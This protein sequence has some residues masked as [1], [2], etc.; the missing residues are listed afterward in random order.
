MFNHAL[1]MAAGRGSRMLPL[2]NIVPKAMAPLSNTTLI[3]SGIEKLKKKI[4]N[5]HVTVGY[6]GAMLASHV[7]EKDVASVFNTEGKGNAW[8]VYHTL[9]QHL[10]EPVLV[11]TCDNVINLNLDLLKKDYI[12]MGQPACTVIPVKPVDG[13][14]G[15][16]IFHENNIV[17]ELNRRKKSDIYCSGIQIINP[18]K[19][20]LLTK[21]VD[22]FYQLWSQLIDSRKLF[23]SKIYPDQWFT[24]DTLS[25]LEEIN[26]IVV[27]SES[28][29][30]K[31]V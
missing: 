8:W 13:L 9:I 18:N 19:V 10:D 3:A 20:N 23:C 27:K 16:Y 21:P 31:K 29:T 4:P 14:A 12:D 15:D 5:I 30:L 22:D 11:L 26:K 6:K 17:L 7:L 2:T 1:I 25:Q 28:S 24:V